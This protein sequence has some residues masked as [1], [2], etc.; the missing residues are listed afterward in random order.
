M[1]ITGGEKASRSG[2]LWNVP[3]HELMVGLKMMFDEGELEIG[4]N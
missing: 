4:K 2:N 3:K 1:T